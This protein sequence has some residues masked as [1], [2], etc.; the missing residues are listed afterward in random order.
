MRLA[1][2]SFFR[3]HGQGAV[4]CIA[5][6]WY[7]QY[8]SSD[9]TG[10]TAFNSTISASYHT[11]HTQGIEYWTLYKGTGASWLPSNTVAMKTQKLPKEVLNITSVWCA[12]MFEVWRVVWGSSSLCE[13]KTRALLK[14]EKYM[15]F[16]FF[17]LNSYLPSSF[18]S[19]YSVLKAHPEKGHSVFSKT[20]IRLR[21]DAARWDMAHLD[22]KQWSKDL[23]LILSDKQRFNLTW[24]WLCFKLNLPV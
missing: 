3:K 24:R 4:R 7:R 20:R 19:I 14:W 22:R 13:V 23:G 15:V 12:I 1:T 5:E 18:L 17:R 11:Y 10:V 8:P 16:F 6:T 9:D 2:V 21:R